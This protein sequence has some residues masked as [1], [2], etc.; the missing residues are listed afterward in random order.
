MKLPAKCW[1]QATIFIRRH[2]SALMAPGWPWLTWNHPNMPW[3]GA[4]LGGVFGDGLL[5]NSRLIGA[6]R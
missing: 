6:V 4:N 5:K 3:T 2:V 1:Y